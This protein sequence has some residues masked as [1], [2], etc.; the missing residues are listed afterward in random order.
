M[1]F[2]G[3]VRLGGHAWESP[4]PDSQDWCANC[5]IGRADLADLAGELKAM[6]DAA[7]P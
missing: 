1:L 7:M 2:M 4:D 6:I 5:G 3:C